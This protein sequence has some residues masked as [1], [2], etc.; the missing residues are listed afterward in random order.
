MRVMA[1]ALALLLFASRPSP[2][3]DC[4]ACMPKAMCV[5]HQ[6]EQDDALREFT[7]NKRSKDPMKRRDALDKIGKLNDTHMNVRGVDVAKAIADMLDDPDSGIRMG[8]LSY[9][10]TN[11]E[12]ETARDEVAK[13]LDKYLPRIGK[14]KPSGKSA[15]SGN[16]GLE[17]ENEVAL[18]KEAVSA[19]AELGGKDAA[20]CFIKVVESN[21][22]AFAID[23]VCK[24]TTIKS[25]KLVETY[26][27]RLNELQGNKGD[28]AKL[29]CGELAKAFASHTS[30]PEPFADDV[31]GWL[32][33]ARAWWKEKQE[34]YDPPPADEP[35]K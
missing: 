7:K 10:K 2:A 3:A 28:E 8:A 24:T 33:K 25:A 31:A 20:G 11:Q 1:I 5:R 15:A 14:P 34:T 18:C 32:K 26:L 29:L 12:V 17:W 9:L 22:Y 23:N 35:P 4:D 19:M 30:F 27:S 6:K 16:A 13:I 21:N